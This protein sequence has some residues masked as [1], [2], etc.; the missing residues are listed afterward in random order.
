M[1]RLSYS[2][3]PF[4]RVQLMCSSVLLL[5]APQWHWMQCQGPMYDVPV[6]ALMGFTLWR[7]FSGFR[8]TVRQP[9]ARAQA[10]LSYCRPSF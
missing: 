5:T 3:T 4:A 1:K 6:W 2:Q 8:L 9:P 10:S 7:V